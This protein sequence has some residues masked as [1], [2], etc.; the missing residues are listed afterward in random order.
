MDMGYTLEEVFVAIDKCGMYCYLHQLVCLKRVACDYLHISIIHS[1]FVNHLHFM[2]LNVTHKYNFFEFV[3][4]DE[5]LFV[6]IDFIEAARVSKE[7]D[8]EMDNALGSH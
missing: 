3:G 4:K 2:Y 8:A 6:L 5:A 1:N 7:E